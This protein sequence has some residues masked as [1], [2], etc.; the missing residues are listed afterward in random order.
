MRL[1]R[2]S[3]DEENFDGNKYLGKRSNAL[4]QPSSSPPCTVN[5]FHSLKPSIV[6]LLRSHKVCLVN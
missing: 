6:N 1:S 2:I 4:D 5:Y 3:N